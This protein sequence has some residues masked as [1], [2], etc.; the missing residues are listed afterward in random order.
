VGSFN[1]QEMPFGFWPSLVSARLLANRLRFEDVQF[2]RDGTVI[3]I[4][5][6]SDRGVLVSKKAGDASREIS[7]QL[8][9]RAGIGYGGG[10]FITNNG[11]VVFSEVGG[12]LYQRGLDYDFPHPITPEF[13][14]AAAPVIS[15]DGKWVIYVFSDGHEDV[16][17]IVDIEGKTW[18]TKLVCGADFYM[19]PVWH[20]E[21]EFLA[22]VEWDHPKMPWNGCRLML[23]VLKGLPPQLVDKKQVDGGDSCPVFQ[24]AFSPDGRWLSYIVRSNDWEKLVILDLKDGQSYTVVEAD[25]FM[26]SK[27]AWVQGARTYG[28]RYD[29]QAIY[30]TKYEAG[31]AS[32]WQVFLSDGRLEAIDTAPYTWINQLSVSRDR[33]QL[34]FIA[35]APG[36]PNRVVLREN[37]KLSC[38]VRSEAENIDPENYAIPQAVEWKNQD[39]AQVY[40]LFYAPA[41]PIFTCKGLPPVIVNIHGGPTSQTVVE[42]RPETAFFTSRGYAWLEVNYRGSTGYGY[43]YMS[44]LEKN[45]GLSDTEDAV[46]AVAYLKKSGMVDGGRVV[47]RGGSAG[48][49]T[50]LNTLVHHPGLLKAG[51]CSYGVADLVDLAGDTHKFEAKYLDQLVGV[52]PQD[53]EIFKQRS[54]IHFI[55]QLR[56]PMAIFHGAKDKVVPPVHSENIVAALRQKGVPFIYR[57]YEGEGHGF[58]KTDTI[59]D[60]L[61]QTNNFLQK[62]V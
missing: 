29:G 19:Q 20:P 57:L 53:S 33:D 16:L 61:E 50:V 47:I 31:Q 15:P 3:W 51:I 32:L 52:L 17:G 8:S 43:Q 54:P 45:W 44:A 13:G 11:K 58:R 26:L 62:Y 27:P 1:K 59:L 4:E 21:G 7:D 49:L 6:R 38:L 2:D 34:A 41:N 36:I 23:G 12:R 40:G 22:W 37:D 60:Y 14:N 42:Y 9:V 48:G 35:S 10:E 55:S 24:P 56:E 18:P 25:K 46:G 28:W 30:F 39:G 5:G